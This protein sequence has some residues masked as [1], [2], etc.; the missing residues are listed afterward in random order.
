[1]SMVLRDK[2]IR[3]AENSNDIKLTEAI[4]RLQRI[5]NSFSYSIGECENPHYFKP[6]REPRRKKGGL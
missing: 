4:Y 1:M 5:R 3:Q 6:D 2:L